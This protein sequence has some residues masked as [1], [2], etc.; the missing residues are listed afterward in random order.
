MSEL[1]D[2]QD[3]LIST[4]F[5]VRVPASDE[6]A[7]KRIHDAIEGIRAILDEA[8]PILHTRAMSVPLMTFDVVWLESGEE[9][10]GKCNR[11][12]RWVTDSSKRNPTAGL[13]DGTQGPD[14]QFLCTECSLIS[15]G[16]LQDERDAPDQ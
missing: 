13:L 5:L 2:E 3:I 9:N 8:S 12:D 7:G 6:I 15:S 11:C 14:G 10:A 1:D 4:A 16:F